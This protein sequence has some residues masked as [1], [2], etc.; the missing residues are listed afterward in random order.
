[1][2]FLNR[3]WTILTGYIRAAISPKVSWGVL[4][5]RFLTHKN[6]FSAIRVKQNAFLP[7]DLKVSVF[8]T[9][10]L[11]A[12]QIWILGQRYVAANIYG[13]AELTLAAVFEIGLKV[14]VDNKP[15]RHA[16]ITGWPVQKSEQKLC[17]LKLAEKSSLLLR[18]E[19]I[20]GQ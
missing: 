11:S 10:G 1:M 16:N 7:K 4:L 8:L 12:E 19:R 17:T 20:R 2:S 9:D 13:R 6:Q 3:L 18:S 15:Q 5:N 14:E